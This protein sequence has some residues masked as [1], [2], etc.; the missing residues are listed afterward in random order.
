MLTNWAWYRLM[1]ILWHSANSLSLLDKI[2]SKHTCWQFLKLV[3]RQSVKLLLFAIINLNSTRN[4]FYPWLWV[5]RFL[6]VLKNSHIAKWKKL[7]TL[8][9]LLLDLVLH[10]CCYIIKEVIPQKYQTS[11]YIHWRRLL[12]TIWIALF[13]C[14]WLYLLS[15]V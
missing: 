8:R 1:T 15:C 2:S 11:T 6:E 4:H 3:D 13:F 9:S 10:F 5:L 7:P 12:E 14:K